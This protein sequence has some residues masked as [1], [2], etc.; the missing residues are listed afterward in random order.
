MSRVECPRFA[1]SSQEAYSVVGS[2]IRKSPEAIWLFLFFTAGSNTPLTQPY[3]PF[4]LK[5]SSGGMITASSSNL[6]F[7]TFPIRKFYFMSTLNY[8]QN[9]WRS[10]FLVSV[11]S[12]KESRLSLYI[13]AVLHALSPFFFDPLSFEIRLEHHQLFIAEEWYWREK[14]KLK[15]LGKQPEQK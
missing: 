9:S 4:F 7:T 3:L 1:A 13:L 15:L 14:R 5:S 6:F 8:H 2:Q 12:G 11:I 10:L